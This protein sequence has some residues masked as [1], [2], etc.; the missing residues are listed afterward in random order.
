MLAPPCGAGP[1]PCTCGAARSGPCAGPWRL[2]GGRSCCLRLRTAR[3][4]LRMRVCPTPSDS[5]SWRSASAVAVDA[6]VPTHRGTEVFPWGTQTPDHQ[7][8]RPRGTRT[9]P[10]PDAGAPAGTTRR[11]RADGTGY[12]SLVGHATWHSLLAHPSCGSRILVAIGMLDFCASPLHPA[13]KPC[14]SFPRLMGAFPLR[15]VFA[16]LMAS[17]VSHLRSQEAGR[18][19]LAWSNTVA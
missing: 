1:S 6:R 19:C 8:I 15:S 14:C 7:V 11:G 10:Q 2:G 3:S 16:A 18:F 13:I 9:R 4:L 17:G 12:A 5:P